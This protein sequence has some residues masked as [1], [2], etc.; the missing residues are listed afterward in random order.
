MPINMK[1]T[2]IQS[3]NVRS[4]G[5]DPDKTILEIEFSSGIYRFFDVPQSIYDAFMASSSKGS[6]F[7]LS[8]KGRFPHQR[9][10]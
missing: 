10:I 1:R 6:F 9:M 7:A 4:V 8:I 3:T 5:Y 2:A